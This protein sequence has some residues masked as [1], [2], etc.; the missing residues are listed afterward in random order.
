MTGMYIDPTVF[1]MVAPQIDLQL[2][3]ELVWGEQ[4]VV[5][6]TYIHS[7]GDPGM[8]SVVKPRKH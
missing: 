1:A 2:P 7:K 6:T 5:S 3:S 4:L 8:Q